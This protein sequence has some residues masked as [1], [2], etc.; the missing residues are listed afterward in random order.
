[1]RPVFKKIIAVCLVLCLTLSGC[2]GIDFIGYFQNLLSLF[3]GVTAFENMD[4]QR[5]DLDAF[6]EALEKACSAATTET[7]IDD[8]ETQIY[9][10]YGAY[11]AFSTAYALSTIHYSQDLTD[12]YW[13]AEY[14]FC[15]ENAATF[16][17]GL[18]QL[19]RALADSPLR[20]KL[21]TEDYFGVGFF[22]YYDGESLYDEPFLDLLEQE[23][24]LQSRYYDISADA[25]TVEYYSEEY[26]SIYGT[27][28]AEVLV[29]LI[30][31]RQQI[32]AYAGYSNYPEFAYDYYHSRD[33]TPEQATSYLADIRAELA[34]LYTRMLYSD[35]YWDLYTAC[36]TQQTFQYVQSMAQSMGGDI[37][38]AFDL[39]ESANLYDIGY[40]P[41]KFNSSFEVYIPSYQL[42][43]VFMCP[44]STISDKLTFAHEFG[45]FC[46]DYVSYGSSAGVDVAE[47]FS[48]GMEYLSLFYTDRDSNL[49]KLKMF[50]CLSTYVEQSALASFEHQMYSLTG[51]NLTVENLQALYA[52]VCNAFGISGSGW[53]SRS[54]VVISHFYTSPLYVI[55]YVVSNDAALQLYQME[56]AQSGSGLTCLQN[57]LGTTE[58]YFLAFLEEAG[59]DSPFADGRIS[60]VKETLL[61]FLPA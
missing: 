48:Q 45:H 57:S 14:N 54:Y 38:D 37:A 52:S 10:F 22:D 35:D 30:A 44:D 43:F 13:E 20:D 58:A 23:A 26:F 55:S 42:P 31:L 5:P 60:N 4:Y 2:S 27:Q 21:E 41:N 49:E 34:P 17:A 33:Y 32:A 7:D 50:S 9:T 11:N 8:L 12:S 59:L 47:I 3:T 16:D 51:D 1:M 29:K 15:L 36:S 61:P 6:Q 46:S 39:M 56:A 24:Q 28:M 18:D 25:N 53:D 40:G 19:Y